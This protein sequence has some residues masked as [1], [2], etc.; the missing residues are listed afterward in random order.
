[1]HGKSSEKHGKSSEKHG[2]FSEKHD[3][4]SE[5]HGKSSEKYGKFSEK[6]GQFSEK[7]RAEDFLPLLKNLILFPKPLESRSPRF[8]MI[9]NAGI[10]IGHSVNNHLSGG[11]EILHNMR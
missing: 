2:K 6:H 10:G 8:G 11:V 4:S 7:S 3:K 9:I 1:M 5:K